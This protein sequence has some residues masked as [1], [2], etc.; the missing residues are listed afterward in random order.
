MSDS[1]RREKNRE[2]CRSWYHD[3]IQRGECV[4][5]ASPSETRMCQ[6]CKDRTKSYRDQK[7][8][9]RRSKG[10]CILCGEKPFM[11]SH[12][13]RQSPKCLKCF[14]KK[15]SSD[16][17]GTVKHWKT[18]LNIYEAQ[19]GLCVYTGAEIVLGKTA[20]LDHIYPKATH[21]Q[22]SADL[23]NLQW[24]HN[25]VNVMKGSID[26]DF[27]LYLCQLISENHDER[28]EKSPQE[29]NHLGQSLDLACSFPNRRG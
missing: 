2:T 15:T 21:P 4:T 13:G 29:Q 28:S 19:G 14:L 5:C 20:D 25:T 22:L 6:S 8:E 7:F 18:L 24:I 26:P 17:L 10:L 16:A 11:E 27:F 9:D 1:V 3:R 12:A 23:N